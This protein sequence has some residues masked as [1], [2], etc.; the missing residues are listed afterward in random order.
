MPTKTNQPAADEALE[1]IQAGAEVDETVVDDNEADEIAAREA[2]AA[3][4]GEQPPSRE[5][6]LADVRKAMQEAEPAAESAPAAD[7]EGDATA[8][9]GK[10]A[11]AA[12]KPVEAAPDA[13]AE[14]AKADAEKAEADRRAAVD[15]EFGELQKAGKDKT[16]DRFHQLNKQVADATAA[17]EAM[18][19]TLTDLKV[20]GEDGKP[21]PLPEAARVLTDRIKAHEE[22]EDAIFSTG[23]NADDF[24]NVAAYKHSI[25]S[26]NP[27]LWEQARTFLRNE[28]NWLETERMG[29]RP[30]EAGV[31]AYTQHKD[32]V[33]KVASGALE[34]ADAN[35]LA[36]GRNLRAA[37]TKAAEARTQDA[38][39]DAVIKEATGKCATL[40]QQ[41][42][43]SEP[44]VFAARWPTLKPKLAEIQKNFPPDQW[45]D[46]MELEYHRIPVQAPAAAA[47]AAAAQP[48]E[49]RRPIKPGA[50]PRAGARRPSA[51][52][53]DVTRDTDNLDPM[54]ALRSG[55]EKAGAQ[56]PD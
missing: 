20:V 49:A 48:V 39:A 7:A 14:A 5:E 4:K 11:A 47:A 22:F 16:R 44:T 53:G 35:E 36:E 38:G 8:G 52:H 15:K 6:L 55:L 1:N 56:L 27:A 3:E 9:D 18:L 46:R 23:V 33:D 13:A 24:K 40:G 26:D 54:D 10:P 31:E 45:A 17:N 32:L 41:L 19:K 43:A 12:E 50:L 2:A 34:I 30:K 37:S 51:D 42:A 28:L 25:N 21:L 29:L